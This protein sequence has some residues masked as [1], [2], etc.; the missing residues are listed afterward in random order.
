MIKKIDITS[1]FDIQFITDE[2]RKKQSVIMTLQ[3][4]NKLME[5]YYDLALIPSRL[6]DTYIPLDKERT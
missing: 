6:D 5:D 2:K 1:S 3:D 4:F